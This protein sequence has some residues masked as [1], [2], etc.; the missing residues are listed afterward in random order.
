[1]NLNLT[2]STPTHPHATVGDLKGQLVMRGEDRVRQAFNGGGEAES[3][4]DS[5]VPW[6]RVQA[7]TK[8]TTISDAAF[9]LA[10]ANTLDARKDYPCCTRRKPDESAFHHSHSCSTC[11]APYWWPRHQRVL[12]TIQNVCSSYGIIATTNFVPY[13]GMRGAT[14]YRDFKQPDLL[15]YR[16]STKESPL[17]LDVTIVSH[18]PTSATCATARAHRMKVEKY[19]DWADK[20]GVDFAPMVF[21]PRA[22]ISQKTLD[23]LRSL[24]RQAT[25]R[26][27]VNEVTR[28]I[29]VTLVEFEVTRRLALSQTFRTPR[30]RC[31]NHRTSQVHRRVRRRHRRHSRLISVKSLH[32]LTS[33]VCNPR[34]R[35]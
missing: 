15:I 26:G 23:A 33:F 19:A 13:G 21:T 32:P 30:H 28:R 16:G 7:V 8:H 25:R 5:S 35:I 12:Q 9:E 10:L 17:A 11:A 29:K 24:Q 14:S 1:M 18:A 31:R 6:V 3:R 27:F 22:T 20:L 4:R 34:H 2:E